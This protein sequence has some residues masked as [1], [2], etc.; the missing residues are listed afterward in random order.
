[1]KPVT[2]VLGVLSIVVFVVIVL[3]AFLM[4]SAA[5]AEQPRI[6]WQLGICVDDQFK[7]TTCRLVGAP[8]PDE[9][10][11]RALRDSLRSKINN[12]RVHCARVLVDVEHDA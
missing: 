4:A 3:A 6:G 8:L 11:C 12:G 1:M 5:Y 10:L 2:Y 9:Q 7:L